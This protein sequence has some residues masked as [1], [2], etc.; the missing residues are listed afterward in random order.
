MQILNDSSETFY[1]SINRITQHFNGKQNFMEI[2]DSSE[3]RQKYF[4]HFNYFYS[5]SHT[6]LS[7]TRFPMRSLNLGECGWQAVKITRTDW[8][9]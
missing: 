7:A 9:F 6:Q 4:K 2:R 8:I 5:F 1:L 3:I